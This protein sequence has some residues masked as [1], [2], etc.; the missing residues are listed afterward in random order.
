MRRRNRKRPLQDLGI[1]GSKHCRYTRLE[2]I[3]FAGIFSFCIRPKFYV[4][5][6]RQTCDVDGVVND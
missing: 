1:H 2:G 4:N 3:Y 6:N 5:Y